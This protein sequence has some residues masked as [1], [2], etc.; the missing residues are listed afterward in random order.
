[1]KINAKKLLQNYLKQKKSIGAFNVSSIEAIQAVFETAEDLNIPALVETS[2]G[3]AHYLTPELVFELCEYFSRKHSVDYVLHLD[4]GK[5]IDF[6][7][8]CLECGYNSIHIDYSD[9]PFI[10]NTKL[11]SKVREMTNKFNAQLEGEVG[12]IALK[13]YK[14]VGNQ[15]DELT[16]P[17]EA[18]CFVY[19]TEVDS[20]AVSIGTESGK[21]KDVQNIDIRRLQNIH[22][23][24]PDIPLVLHGGSY[25]P[26]EIYKE[27]RKHG[28]AK[29][30]INSELREAYTKTLLGNKKL[31]PD[32]YAPYR[33]FRGTTE[34]M[35]KVVKKK[36]LIFNF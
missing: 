31:H 20:L 23:L 21:Y 35:K 30:N 28:I 10:K 11:T 5:D 25:L 32:E 24:L 15:S 22:S 19:K 4:H 27:V 3:E 33:L 14:D 26:E 36:M 1:M 9:S 8:K 16:N 29:I 6:I 13:Y 18:K 17:N 12:V 2:E 34:A 7:K